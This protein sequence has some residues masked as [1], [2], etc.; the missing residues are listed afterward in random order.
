[1]L[2]LKNIIK[3]Q[4]LKGI[5]VS[6]NLYHKDMGWCVIYNDNRVCNLEDYFDRF[7]GK[8]VKITVE[9]YEQDESHLLGDSNE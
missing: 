3:V 4:E 8:Y 2:K 9:T 1:M 6:G 7:E 5:E